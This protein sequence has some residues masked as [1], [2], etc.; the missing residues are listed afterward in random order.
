MW[1]T[2]TESLPGGRGILVAVLRDGAPVSYLEVLKRWQDDA[3]FRTFFIGVLAAA[4]YQAFRWE[5]PPI[6]TSTAARPFEFVL[7]DSPGLASHPDP[8][9]F[10][11]HFR[12]AA[13]GAVV[14][15]QNLGKDSL[16]VV[17]CPGGA[18]AAYGHLAAFVRGAP[19]EQQHAL[20][21]RV[22]EAASRRLGS[23]PVWISTAGAGVSWLHVRLDD[24]PK[25]YGHAPYRAAET[26]PTL[27]ERWFGRREE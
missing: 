16:L 1:A 20:W 23:A 6:T 4:P 8:L 10:A 26:R 19:D 14:S 25:Y 27:R 11:E 17:P 15:F 9:P 21:Q 13:D 24:R 18:Q 12:S 5:T 3:A 22:G 7:L 2:R